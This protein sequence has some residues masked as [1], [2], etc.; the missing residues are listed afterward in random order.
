M[1]KEKQLSFTEFDSKPAKIKKKTP[2][3]RV[4]STSNALALMVKSSSHLNANIKSKLK[5]SKAT[6]RMNVSIPLQDALDLIA[7]YEI[8]LNELSNN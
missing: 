7:A 6:Q 4:K 5:R 2:T 8:A 1:C 3:E